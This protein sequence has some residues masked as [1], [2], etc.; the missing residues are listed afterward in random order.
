MIHGIL[1]DNDGNLWLSTHKGLSKFD[2]INETFR[3]YDVNDGLQSN[4]FNGG[5]YFK[6]PRTGEMFFGGVNGFNSFFPENIID[7][8][9]VPPI[10]ITDFQLSNKSIP[11]GKLPLTKAI[12]ETEEIM[13]SYQ[14]RVFSFEFAAL[15]FACPDKNQYAYKMD[16]L[17]K[18]WNF[19]G[20]RRFTT[21][22]NLSPG[23][24]VFRVKRSNCDGV[25]NEEGTAI[26]IR[27]TPPWWETWWA[28]LSYFILFG[29][30]TYSIIRFSINRSLLKG[31]LALKQGTR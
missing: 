15:H 11:T 29:G 31:E 12:T 3:N 16:G 5:A 6:S 10:V 1:E 8:S 30:I 7:N 4:E 27:I 28:Y 2:P 13:L 18:N 17:D 24:Y 23:K 9:Y 25:W 19:I 26:K 22:T 21:F 20:T 14:D